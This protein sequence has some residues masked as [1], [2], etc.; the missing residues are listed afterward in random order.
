MNLSRSLL[1]NFKKLKNIVLYFGI[2]A[3]VIFF[4]ILVPNYF[5]ISNLKT[6]LSTMGVMSVLGVGITFVLTSGEIDISI[7]ALLSVPPVIIAILLEAGLPLL[8]GL[9]TGFAAA[10]LAGFLNGII[11]TKLKIPSFITTIGVMGIAMGASRTI[12]GST[13]IK[14]QSKLLFSIF[15]GELIGIPVIVIWMVFLTAVGYFLLHKTRFGKNIHCV[16]DNRKVAFLNGI[17]I[18]KTV[19]LT[20]LVCSIYVFFAGLLM[21]GLTSFASPGVGEELVL[22]VIV[23]SLIGGTS[24]QGGRGSII[25]TFFGAFFIAVIRSGFFSINMNPWWGDI[26]LGIIIIFVLCIDSL[27]ENGKMY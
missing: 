23:I 15:S 26:T 9:I 14:V 18:T 22:P 27:K 11:T 8:V 13:A 19:T 5:S 1:N 7:G 25:G 3:V 6:I 24:I 21:I 17:N 16:G 2:A 12:S 10:L 4:S 20:F